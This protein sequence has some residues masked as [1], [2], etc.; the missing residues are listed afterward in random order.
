ME[1]YMRQRSAICTTTS[2]IAREHIGRHTI[3]YCERR[4]LGFPN[5]SH[6]APTYRC[7]RSVIVALLEHQKAAAV[8]VD[9]MGR[10]TA[11]MYNTGEP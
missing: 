8:V 7:M 2:T 4:T 6:I 10:V 5:H 11:A 1:A 9:T 3:T